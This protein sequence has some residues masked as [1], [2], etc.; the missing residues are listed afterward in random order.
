MSLSGIWYR[1]AGAFCA[2][3]GHYGRPAPA[4]DRFFRPTVEKFET[5]AHVAMCLLDLLP[6][7]PA[8]SFPA[9]MNYS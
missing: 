5:A 7:T 4:Y 3:G 6:V 1:L 9:V 2:F 8:I